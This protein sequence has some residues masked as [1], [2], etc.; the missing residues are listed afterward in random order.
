MKTV[1]SIAIN[2][3]EDLPLFGFKYLEGGYLIS[4]YNELMESFVEGML[5]GH[6]SWAPNPKKSTFVHFE[7]SE[8][9][10]T[11][12]DSFNNIISNIQVYNGEICIGCCEEDNST[13]WIKDN[14]PSRMLFK[15]NMGKIKWMASPY[16]PAWWSK[17][18]YCELSFCCR[19]C[20]TTIPTL[21]HNSNHS[22]AKPYTLKYSLN[23]ETDHP[24]SIFSGWYYKGHFGDKY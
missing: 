7:L 9:A 12:C 11:T 20:N 8:Q 5:S 23:I 1:R 10:C 14:I 13:Q 16:K 18:T 6:L 3:S 21:M 15:H 24:F 17:G 19:H 22:N 2:E 4:R